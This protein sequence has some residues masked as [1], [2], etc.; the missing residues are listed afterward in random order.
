MF[1]VGLG[2]NFKKLGLDGTRALSVYL[3]AVI[4]LDHLQEEAQVC[5][6]AGRKAEKIC[7]GFYFVLGWLVCVLRCLFGGNRCSPFG[8]CPAF[9]HTWPWHPVPYQPGTGEIASAAACWLGRVRG[10]LDG[11]R[12]PSGR[13]VLGA[14]WFWRADAAVERG[15]C[16]VGD[17]GRPGA[18]S[19]CRVPN[20]SDKPHLGTPPTAPARGP[21][22]E[23]KDISLGSLSLRKWQSVVRAL[24]RVWLPPLLRMRCS[25]AAL[26]QALALGICC[27]SKGQIPNSL[28][29][30]LGF[31]SV[32]HTS[33]LDL[34]GFECARRHNVRYLGYF[35]AKWGNKVFRGTFLV[36]CSQCMV[37]NSG[38][39]CFI[40]TNSRKV[41]I[42]ADLYFITLQ[43]VHER[44]ALRLALW[45]FTLFCSLLGSGVAS[46]ENG[47][48]GAP[49]NSPHTHLTSRR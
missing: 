7:L 48:A 20:G 10:C 38:S 13:A 45:L 3:S 4:S 12:Q 40:S 27:A 30:G 43:S 19:G 42:R 22:T 35:I 44:T 37:Y 1:L 18:Q 6:L 33:W 2:S 23:P 14:S 41:T 5:S 8:T 21:R 9:S 46:W 17:G 16:N 39:T 32:F 36:L 15:K 29:L 11:V 47:Q 25:L 24:P 34:A 26:W 28:C 49:V 31:G